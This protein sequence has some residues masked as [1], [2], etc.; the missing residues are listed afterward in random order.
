MSYE[1]LNEEERNRLAVLRGEG[2]SLRAISRVLRA[3]ARNFMPRNPNAIPINRDGEPNGITP[4][5]GT[6]SSKL[7]VQ[8]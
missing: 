2:H 3:F 7:L 6:L 1:H 5:F 4:A 8:H